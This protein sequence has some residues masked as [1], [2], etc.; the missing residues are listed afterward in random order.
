MRIRKALISSAVSAAIAFF[1][2]PAA[3]AQTFFQSIFGNGGAAAPQQ[4][5]A[6]RQYTIPPHRFSAPRARPRQLRETT[7]PQEEEIGPP[8][9]GGPYRTVCVRTCD[10]FYFPVRARAKRKNFA[11]D[12]RSCRAACGTDAKLYYAP[13]Y[14]AAGA[15]ALVDLAGRKYSDLPHAFAYRKALTAGCTCKPVPWSVEEAQRHRVYAEQEA[16]E[17]AK[18]QAYLQAKA[19]AEAKA[20]PLGGKE[21]ETAFASAALASQSGIVLGQFIVTSGAAPVTVLTH[22][23]GKDEIAAAG[24]SQPGIAAMATAEPQRA[25]AANDEMPVAAQRA[26]ERPV[27]RRRTARL[28]RP[29]IQRARYVPTASGFS[30]FGKSKYLWPGD[31]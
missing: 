11:A 17:L 10:G 20:R 15:D 31:R 2:T 21:M 22:D 13:A 5:M 3:K 30:A 9:S 27:G 29:Q 23:A 4:S 19:A 8:D 7:E 24:A 12:V 18:D 6:P 16:I 28:A 1:F 26:A 14:T 25:Q